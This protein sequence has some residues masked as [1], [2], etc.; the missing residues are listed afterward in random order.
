MHLYACCI[1]MHANERQCAVFSTCFSAAICI[2]EREFWQCVIFF[3]SM[4]KWDL[5]RFYVMKQVILHKIKTTAYK[6][7]YSLWPNQIGVDRLLSLWIRLRLA[8]IIHV[9]KTGSPSTPIIIKT[10]PNQLYISNQIGSL[11]MSVKNMDKH[12]YGSH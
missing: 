1:L 3:N 11:A 6:L 9:I 4:W 7:I 10:G 2:N 5:T 12:T 8:R